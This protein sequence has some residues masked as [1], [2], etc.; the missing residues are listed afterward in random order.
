MYYLGYKNMC[1]NIK[2]ENINELLDKIPLLEAKHKLEE[3]N[4]FLEKTYPKSGF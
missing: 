2:S 4:K 3:E 1:K